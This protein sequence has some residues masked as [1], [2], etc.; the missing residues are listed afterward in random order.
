MDTLVVLRNE[1]GKEE[2][3]WSCNLTPFP[4]DAVSDYN[5]VLKS[6]GFKTLPDNPEPVKTLDEMVP[7]LC[8]CHTCGRARPKRGECPK[9]CVESKPFGAR[10]WRS[11]VELKGKEQ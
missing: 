11:F 3:F 6:Y 1:D 5:V 9:G 2:S 7:D 10:E 8:W 4:H